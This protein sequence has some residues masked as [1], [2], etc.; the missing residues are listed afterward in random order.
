MCTLHI[1]LRK[2]DCIVYL[3]ANLRNPILLLE[4]EKSHRML[5]HKSEGRIKTVPVAE[6][7]GAVAVAGAWVAVADWED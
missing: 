4:Q 7:A 5:G 3:G 6:T 1:Q 2:I